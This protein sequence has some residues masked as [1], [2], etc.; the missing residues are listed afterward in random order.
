M[1]GDKINFVFQLLLLILNNY[2]QIFLIDNKLIMLMSILPK[3]YIILKKIPDIYLKFFFISPYLG[4]QIYYQFGFIV[5][6]IT[7]LNYLTSINFTQAKS[8]YKRRCE[9]I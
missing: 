8:R 6:T 2:W 7:K 4:W 1:A 5:D 3:N 9:L